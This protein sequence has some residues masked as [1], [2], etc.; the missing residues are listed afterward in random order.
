LT[1]PSLAEP[2]AQKILRQFSHYVLVGGTAFA[3]DFCILYL[4]TEQVGLHYLGSATIAFIAGLAVNYALCITWVFDTRT[5][6][7]RFNE[8]LVFGLIGVAGLLLNNAL[9]YLLTDK[10]GLHYLL[11]KLIAAGVVLVFN[12][13]LR[14]TILFNARHSAAKPPLDAG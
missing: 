12:F 7:S 14:R 9:M 10:K 5:L 4:L 1:L 8:F 13:S 11:S 6:K 2:D 3:V